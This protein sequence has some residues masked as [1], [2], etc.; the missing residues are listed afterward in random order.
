MKLRK[1]LKDR[2]W[3]FCHFENYPKGGISDI[4]M[5]SNDKSKLLIEQDKWNKEWKGMCRGS[6]ILNRGN[7]GI[8]N[9]IKYQ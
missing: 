9:N 4:Y 8:T 3:L 6:Y 5:T 1:D 7:G 2:F